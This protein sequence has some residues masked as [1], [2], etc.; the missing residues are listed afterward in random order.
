MLGRGP[1]GFFEPG[2]LK[3]GEDLHMSDFYERL[4]NLDGIENVEVIT[5]KKV[6][7][8]YLNRADSGLIVMKA[9]ELAVCDNDSFKRE[10]GMF[11][12]KFE[13]GRRG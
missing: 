4:M 3:V 2:R 8:L 10:R 1:G 11:R 7:S 9:K 12:F 13:G 5:F 6:G